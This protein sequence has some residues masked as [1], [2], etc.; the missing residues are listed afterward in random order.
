MMID[1]ILIIIGLVVLLYSILF[2][3]RDCKGKVSSTMG[4]DMS[5]AVYWGS[6]SVFLSLGVLPI[7]EI[8]RWW[9]I[10]GF[11]VGV[12]V[13][14][15]MRIVIMKMFCVAYKQEPSGFQKFIRKTDGKPGE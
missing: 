10:A 4:G 3:A 8:S 15:P 14:V 2:Y 9:S 7:V 6:G 11:L 5:F 13:L 12:M 1:W